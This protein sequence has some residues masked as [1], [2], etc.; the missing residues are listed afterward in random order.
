MSRKHGAVVT[1]AAQGRSSDGDSRTGAEQRRGQAEG[2]ATELDPRRRHRT[3]ASR[4]R[5]G[6]GRT[7]AGKQRALSVLVSRAEQ[8][9][10]SRNQARTHQYGEVWP[11][12]PGT[13]QPWLG[14]SVFSCERRL[15]EED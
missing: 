4:G 7:G 14:G 15:E 10:S 1:A 11:S 9:T 12:R 13:W 2:R 5:G 8:S 6:G 3:S